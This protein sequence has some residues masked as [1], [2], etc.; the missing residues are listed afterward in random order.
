LAYQLLTGLFVAGAV[1]Q[2]FLA[3][4]GVFGTG[5]SFEIH[6]TVGTILALASIV[7]LILAGIL[8]VKRVRRLKSAFYERPY[9]F[10]VRAHR[11]GAEGQ[12][13]RCVP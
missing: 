13:R 5:A 6:A 1:L 9:Q 4:L 10:F 8:T 3:S 12:A 11:G 2:F 7:L